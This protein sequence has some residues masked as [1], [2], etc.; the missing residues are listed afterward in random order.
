MAQTRVQQYVRV[1]DCGCNTP[2]LIALFK[3][4]PNRFLKGHYPQHA[5]SYRR[6][7]YICRGTGEAKRDIHRIRAEAAL[8]RPLPKGAI[9]HHPDEDPWNPNARLV[10]CESH[11]FHLFLHLR[12]RVKAAG[13][14]PNTDKI[15]SRCRIP[16]AHTEFSANKAHFDGLEAYCRSCRSAWMKARRLAAEVAS[17]IDFPE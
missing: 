5:P 3:G 10:I 1:C 11:A 8:G 9:V 2:T 12:M 15:C 7:G 4:Q 16:K 13:G 17:G 6:K 14:N